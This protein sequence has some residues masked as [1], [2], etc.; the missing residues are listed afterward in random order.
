MSYTIEL[1]F[2]RDSEAQLHQVWRS[3]Q[4]IYGTPQRSELGVEP[5]LALAV[6]RGGEPAGCE[7]VVSQLARGVTPF[8][9]TFESVDSFPTA[10][11]V[12]YLRAKPTPHL[13]EVHRE[14]HRLLGQLAPL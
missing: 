14:L 11:G 7:A 13:L 8:E 9:L 6:F 2:D 5:H 10:E 3:L 1:F 12:V 4:R